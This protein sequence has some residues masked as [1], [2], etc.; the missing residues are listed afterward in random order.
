MR[1]LYRGSILLA[2]CLICARLGRAQT[3]TLDKTSLTFPSAA[4]GAA[5]A[6][7]IITLTNS[8][9]TALTVNSVAL[10]GTNSG[11]FVQASACKSVAAAGNCTI[12]VTFKP[13]AAGSRTAAVTITDSAAGSPHSVT[14][15]GT[16]TAA[17]A[18]STAA[19]VCK[20]TVTGA[21]AYTDLKSGKVSLP[22]GTA[23]AITGDVSQVTVTGGAL[24][25]L[26]APQSVNGDYGTSDGVT[27]AMVDSPI[28]GTAWTVNLGKLSPDSS[29]TVNF[30]FT[31]PLAP[32]FV[33]T[34][35]GK[36]LGDPAFTVATQQFAAIAKGKPSA[37]QMAAAALMAQTAAS[38]VTSILK[39]NGLIPK[40]PDDL[41]TALGTAILAKIEPVYNV[42]LEMVTLQNPIYHV[43]ELLGTTPADLAKWTAQQ[44]ADA[45]RGKTLDYSKVPTGNRADVQQEVEQFP[46]S[47]DDAAAG[48]TAGVQGAIFIGSASLAVGSD[49]ATDV[50]CDLQKYAGFDVGALY[51]PRLNELRSFFMVH[52]YFGTVDAHPGAPPPKHTTGEWLR[53]R[54]SLALGMALADV[55]GSSNSKISG[56]NAFIYGLGFRL[57]KYFRITG[58]GLLYRTTLPAGSNGMTSPANGAL[59]HEFFIG[60]SIDI[61][62]LS[63]LQSLFAKSK[64]N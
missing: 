23:F 44:L 19:P 37:E 53:Q 16:A 60:P 30:H 40:S 52:I 1:N 9:G 26:I 20:S 12:S 62:G 18:A 15:T 46:K 64:S 47:F 11:D 22:Y 28:T 50:V 14:L 61:T 10:T 45:I 21:I 32:T 25:T 8:G 43:A 31:G 29:V 5:S 51:S 27:G 48:L 13:T 57:N 24:N 39:T 36:M 2:S 35:L 58:G 38:I 63:A 55:S 7:Q 17:A 42:N 34:V 54:T 6:A 59:R 49:Q 3:V 41:K 4:V 56:E 33:N